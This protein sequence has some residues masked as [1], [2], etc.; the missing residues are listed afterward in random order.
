MDDTELAPTA[1]E[2][3]LEQALEAVARR[4]AGVTASVDGFAERQQDLLG[5]DYS[6]DLALIH[7]SCE[8]LRQAIGSLAQKPA[9]AL[10]PEMIARQ[11]EA[12]GQGDRRDAN[13]A[14]VAAQGSLQSSIAAL[15]RVTG[16]VRAAKRQNQI[17]AGAAGLAL[18]L[19]WVGGWI[20]SPVIDWLVPEAWHWP[21]K[22]AESAL[23][24]GGWEA[25][26]RLLLVN[27]PGRWRAIK[28]AARIS[29]ANSHAIAK[30]ASR[31]EERKLKSVGC[32]IEVSATD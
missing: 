8:G 10:T 7:Q 23:R 5:R 24:R 20:V 17:L 4:L 6:E 11:I 12:A 32:L 29:D 15:S 28:A 2:I 31:A 3:P 18:V 9:L 26:E 25:G 21:E 30:C 27:D 22:R 13:Q 16:S 14:L 19:G 1:D